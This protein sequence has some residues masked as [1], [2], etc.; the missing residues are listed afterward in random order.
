MTA[1]KTKTHTDS[2][3]CSGTRARI[4][5]TAR[6]VAANVPDA[7]ETVK[8][9]ALDAYR[10]VDTMPRA[11]RTQ[12]TAISVAVGALLFLFGAP[13]LLSLL[14]FIPAL[15]VAGTKVAHRAASDR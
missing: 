9:T 15:A 1:A 5:A 14:A 11:Q 12:L 3:F 8:S 13:R 2:S 10:M 6:D 7:A 4:K